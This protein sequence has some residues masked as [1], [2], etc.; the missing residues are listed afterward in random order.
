M[1]T[2]RHSA[3]VFMRLICIDEA[4]L[5]NSYK[6]LVGDRIRLRRIELGYSSQDK[7]ADALHKA[8]AK[9]IDQSRVSRWESGAS[10]PSPEFRPFLLRALKMSEDQLFA[11]L[12]PA[13]P[14]EPP[15]P[16]S[17]EWTEVAR[18][19]TALVEASPLRQLIALYVATFDS[20]YLDQIRQLPNSAPTVQFLKSI[21]RR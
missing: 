1:R 18:L 7:L 12:V 14:P 20:Q 6:K 9:N 21:P 11:R 2:S 4:K 8:G 19:L 10:L 13:T 17:A 16:F 3:S 5:L 15:E